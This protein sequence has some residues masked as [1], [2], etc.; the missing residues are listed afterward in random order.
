MKRVRKFVPD[1]DTVRFVNHGLVKQTDR[2]RVEV[3]TRP[4][5]DR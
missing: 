3:R 1:P 5:S 2:Q 4:Y